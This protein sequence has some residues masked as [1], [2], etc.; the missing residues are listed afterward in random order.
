MQLGISLAPTKDQK[1]KERR[2]L[3]MRHLRG[4]RLL[5]GSCILSA[6]RA[7]DLR[8]G[9]GLWTQSVSKLPQEVG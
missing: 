8:L 6:P 3:V 7:P 1:R 2:L 5:R 4:L 9:E